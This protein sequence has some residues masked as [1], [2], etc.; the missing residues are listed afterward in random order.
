MARLIKK[1]VNIRLFNRH[2][3]EYQEESI[4]VFDMDEDEWKGWDAWVEVKE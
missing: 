2:S 3:D 4:V 1:L